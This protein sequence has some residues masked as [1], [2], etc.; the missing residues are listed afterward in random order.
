MRRTIVILSWLVFFMIAVCDTHA[1]QL[2]DMPTGN[3]SRVSSFENMNGIPG[4]GGL[5]NQGS[6]GHSSE[7]LN[8]G[9][10]KT[11]LNISQPGIINRMWFTVDNRSARMLRSLRLRMYWDNQ[12]KPAV[13]VPF[14]DFFCAGLG[15]P[16]AFQSDLFT[17]P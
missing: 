6:K 17:N 2:Y 15:I 14:G 3:Q 10:S 13:D 1:Q 9:E 8:A 11:L 4:R 12:S 7:S 5:T 16:V